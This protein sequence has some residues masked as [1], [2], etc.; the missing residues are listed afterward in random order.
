[1]GH[2]GCRGLSW[3]YVGCR[4][5]TLAVVGLRWLSWAYIGQRGLSWA[6]VSWRDGPTLAGV[7]GLPW[8]AWAVVGKT[9]AGGGNEVSMGQKW[10]AG[11]VGGSKRAPGLQNTTAGAAN[12]CY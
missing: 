1:M 2:A 7:M 6:Y 8:P 12:K 4:G 10:G 5:P 3:A 9:G 11:N